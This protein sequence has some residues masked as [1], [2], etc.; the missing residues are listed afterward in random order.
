MVNMSQLGLDSKLNLS[1]VA[2][3]HHKILFC[4]AWSGT[5]EFR[6][7]TN[8]LH[9]TGL[10]LLRGSGDCAQRLLVAGAWNYPT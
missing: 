6:A 7:K 8:S 5:E 9:A 3:R 10:Y 1:V 2:Y 4:W